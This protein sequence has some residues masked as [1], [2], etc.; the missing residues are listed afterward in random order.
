MSN[1]SEATR[2]IS[3]EAACG[4]VAGPLFVATFA[5][6][7]AARSGHDWRRHALSSLACGREGWPQRANVIVTGILYCV[8]ARGLGH[9]PRRVVGP[10]LVPALVG[11]AGAGLIGS[12]LFVTDPVAGSPPPAVGAEEGSGGGASARRTAASPTRARPVRCGKRCRSCGTR[13]PAGPG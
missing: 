1:G 10:R 12:G 6:I 8:A 4:V 5:A 7:G 2:S 11:A 3:R 9:A 13:S